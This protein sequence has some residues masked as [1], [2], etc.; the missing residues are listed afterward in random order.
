MLTDEIRSDRR[1]R[2]RRR[3]HGLLDLARAD[4][5]DSLWSRSSRAAGA[6]GRATAANPI[7]LSSNENP[8]GPGQKVLDAVKAAFGPAGAAPGRYSGASGALIEALAKKHNVQPA[9]ITLG[10]GSTQ[11]LRDGDARLHGAHQ[12]AGRHDSDL[13]GVRRLRRHDGPPGAR[14]AARRRTSTWISTGW[15]DRRARR[16]ARLLL[17]P[18]QPDGDL[19][20]RARVARLLRARQPHLA[21]D[22]D[23]R[24]RGVLRLRH[25]TPITRPTS[26]SPSKTRASSSRGR[27]RRRTAWPA[28]ASATRSG[29][30]TR[31]AR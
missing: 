14:G 21:G 23:P 19:H 15:L 31:S 18:E 20:R 11:I 17:Q 30:R 5:K 6:D 8:L 27:S 10:C 16:R 22:D 9:N 28:C 24:R 4:A 25:R 12:G 7:I 2:R 26:R 3:G 13:R 1:A 29:T